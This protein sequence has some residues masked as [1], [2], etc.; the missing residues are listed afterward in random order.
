MAFMQWN[1]SLSVKVAEIDEQHKQLLSMVNDLHGAM[2]TGR[3]KDQCSEII[4]GLI[5]Y[6][7]T[8]FSTEERYFAK[9]NY[10]EK[11][12]H[13][14]EHRVFVKKVKEFQA[15]FE[16]GKAMITIEI[17]QFLNEWLVMHIRGTDQKYSDFLNSKG[18]K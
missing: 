18:V 1:D 5:R 4:S 12:A 10:P 6:T 15:G 14:K 16:S 7:Q 3:A 2:K 11:S 8:H 13:E 9:Y 17:M